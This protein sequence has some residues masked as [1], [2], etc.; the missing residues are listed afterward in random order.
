M[1]P[2]L[3]HRVGQVANS[4]KCIS[5]ADSLDSIFS[6]FT[7]CLNSFKG[8]HHFFRF[9]F[10]FSYVPTSSSFF[11][12]KYEIKVFSS[13]SAVIHKHYWIWLN[14]RFTKAGFLLTKCSKRN[15]VTS[16]LQLKKNIFN[17]FLALL[18]KLETKIQ[19]IFWFWWN[20]NKIF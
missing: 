2:V 18:W 10:S 14:D 6:H 1:A 7:D 19:A 11:L 8:F 20:G 13:F 16:L 15:L 4:G 3:S 9:S 5:S 17:L 12:L